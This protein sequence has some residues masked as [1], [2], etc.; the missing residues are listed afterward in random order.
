MNEQGVESNRMTNDP[1]D[2]ANLFITREMLIR[3]SGN[4]LFNETKRRS[5]AAL[6]AYCGTDLVLPGHVLKNCRILA[7][8]AQAKKA[9]TGSIE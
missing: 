5:A 4:V 2:L 6:C 9:L 7:W 1:S 3:E 8:E